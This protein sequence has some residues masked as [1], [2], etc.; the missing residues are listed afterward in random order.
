MTGMV[1]LLASLLT[2]RHRYTQVVSW[3]ECAAHIVCLTCQSGPQSRTVQNWL[4]QKGLR[5]RERGVGCCVYVYLCGFVFSHCLVLLQIDKK[6]IFS[7]LIVVLGWVFSFAFIKCQKI[8]PKVSSSNYSVWTNRRDL[9]IYLFSNCVKETK[10]LNSH[11]WA[12]GTV[13]YLVLL[14]RGWINLNKSASEIVRY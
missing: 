7:A 2:H 8:V 6:K 10:A 3:A 1:V 14:P 9:F 5:E 11:T 13:E 12:S 4:A